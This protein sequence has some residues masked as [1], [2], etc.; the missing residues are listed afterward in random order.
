MASQQSSH[1]LVECH[2][3]CGHVFFDLWPTTEPP[4]RL[5]LPNVAT[6]K[7]HASISS[8]LSMD[9]AADPHQVLL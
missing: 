6:T 1:C 9:G 2:H 5:F 8:S 3:Q 7:A 4:Q